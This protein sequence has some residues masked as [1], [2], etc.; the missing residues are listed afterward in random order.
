M[1]VSESSRRTRS[2]VSIES[3]LQQ[4]IDKSVPVETME[5]LLAMRTQLK[6]ERAKEVYDRSMADFQAE[7]PTIVKTKEVKT[8]SGQVA[9]MYAPIESIVSQVKDLLQKHAFSYSSGMELMSGG[10]KVKLR[11]THS[12]GHS[13][14]FF[15]EVPFGT[16]TDIM[17]QTQVTAAATTFAKRYAFCNAFG[18]LTG[19]E[20]TDSK[21]E[22]AQKDRMTS[23]QVTRVIPDESDEAGG[24]VHRPTPEEVSIAQKTIKTVYP[25][26]NPTND[27]HG[28]DALTDKKPH[29]IDVGKG[30]LF[31][32]KME[33][34]K[35]LKE[36]RNYL[37]TGKTIEH[38]TE[39]VMN[40]TGIKLDP[41]N[42]DSIIAELRFL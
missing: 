15:M 3:L 17:S 39:E 24:Y 29:D 4:A 8:R 31:E 5:R 9:Y 14:E 36:K 12:G 42:Y 34:A 26:M 1:V 2:N 11:V 25:D 27:A 10:V 41:A 20:D 18:I 38:V 16:K 13:E 21:A 35:L 19:D 40:A 22:D 30:E 6:Q 23:Y 33:I 7:C 37:M 28:L 32:K